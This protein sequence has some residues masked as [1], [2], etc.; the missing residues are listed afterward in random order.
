MIVFIVHFV[1]NAMLTLLR[2]TRFLRPCPEN[3]IMTKEDSGDKEKKVVKVAKPS[4]IKIKPDEMEKIIFELAKEGKT[5]GQI[6]LVL[7]DKYGIPKARLLGKGIQ[8]VLNESGISYNSDKEIIQGKIKR[9]EKHRSKNKHDYT[10][11]RALTKRL[12]DVYGLEK[13]N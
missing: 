6:G 5:P 10:A 7:R 2:A 12:W 9:L 13:H 8:N 11:S 1:R 4:W 3:K